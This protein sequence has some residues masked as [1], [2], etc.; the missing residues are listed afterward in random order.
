MSRSKG[1]AVERKKTKEMDDEIIEKVKSQTVT[2]MEV[3]VLENVAT[4]QRREREI[5]TADQQWHPNYKLW[6]GMTTPL[7]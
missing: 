3:T 1:E 5:W 2:G 7:F 6:K 4:A